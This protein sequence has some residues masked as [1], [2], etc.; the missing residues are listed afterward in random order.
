[1]EPTRHSCPDHHGLN[2]CNCLPLQEQHH[3]LRHSPAT[4][5]PRSLSSGSHVCF[6]SSQ[7]VTNGYHD[8][9]R[10][11]DYYGANYDNMRPVYMQSY[12]QSSRFH[13][14]SLCMPSESQRFQVNFAS[15]TEK[16]TQ[17]STAASVSGRKRKPSSTKNTQARKRQRVPVVPTTAPPS[18]ICGVGPPTIVE[19]RSP[20][21]TPVRPSTTATGTP[22][23][24]ISASFRLPTHNRRSTELSVAATD[25]WYFCR[26][27]DSQTKPVERLA[28]DQ[29]QVLTR[30]PR[31]MYISCKLCSES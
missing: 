16:R 9:L 4:L 7:P 17:E 26:P 20:P 14:A 24:A 23:H 15:P 6:P 27:Q 22:S 18:A 25:V 1:M 12:D 31:S 11:H 8:I 29:D 28:P 3:H 10:P 19:N 2:S 5:T 21:S 13:Q 30:R